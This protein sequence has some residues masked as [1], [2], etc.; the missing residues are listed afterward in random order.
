MRWTRLGSHGVRGER[1]RQKRVVLIPRRWDQV[2]RRQPA[3]DG[4]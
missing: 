2:C 3:G 1:G 4:G